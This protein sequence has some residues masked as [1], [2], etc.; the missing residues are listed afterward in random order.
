MLS[1]KYLG[2]ALALATA[3]TWQECHGAEDSEAKTDEACEAVPTMP[4]AGVDAFEVRR[5]KLGR[6]PKV[7]QQLFREYFKSRTPVIMTDQISKA[8]MKKWK[9]RS[10]KKA[11]GTE[12]VVVTV[13]P[14]KWVDDRESN[15]HAVHNYVTSDIDVMIQ[16]GAYLDLL[17]SKPPEG[18]TKKTAKRV[19]GTESWRAKGKEGIMINWRTAEVYLRT[20][21]P[22]DHRVRPRPLF[23]YGPNRNRC[24][25]PAF[26]AGCNAF[27]A[28]TRSISW[29]AGHCCRCHFFSTA[30]LAAA[31][32][33][34]AAAATAAATMMMPMIVTEA[35]MST[36]AQG[37]NLGPKLFQ[38]HTV[39][40]LIVDEL[41]A[42]GDSSQ[43]PPHSSHPIASLVL[44]G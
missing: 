36:L 3:A 17:D 29:S 8:T 10:Q 16:W 4:T 30:A 11:F 18:V 14:N 35:R 19:M 9:L 43:Q 7:A 37:D 21:I 41:A 40:D 28:S 26:W 44:S 42:D 31:L 12:G 22:S 20:T 6:K 39:P 15:F 27:N 34:A 24:S 13:Q 23:N 5:V 33:A 32:A 25:L 38:V 1:L 2:L